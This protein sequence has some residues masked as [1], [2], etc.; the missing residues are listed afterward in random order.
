MD[1]A[2]GNAILFMVGIVLL[3]FGGIA[4]FIINLALRARKFR[5][6]EEAKSSS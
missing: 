3:V 2:T 6:L 5:K 4:F 1:I